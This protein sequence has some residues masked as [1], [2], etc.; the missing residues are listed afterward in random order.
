[1]IFSR[2]FELFEFNKFL[3]KRMAPVIVSGTLQVTREI[4]LQNEL[5]S[6]CILRLILSNAVI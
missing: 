6:R 4:L 2:L 5:E 1:M 3:E